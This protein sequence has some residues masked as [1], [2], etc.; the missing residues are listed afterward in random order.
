M[1]TIAENTTEVPVQ[2]LLA[3]ELMVIDGVCGGVT[4]IVI[5]LL[6]ASGHGP[7]DV[8]EQVIISPLFK[9][10]L[11][12]V[13][14]F[15]PA[16]TPFIAHCNTGE[17]PALTSVAVKFAALPLQ[18][19]VVFEVMLMP[20]LG[21]T[22]IVTLSFE[23]QPLLLLKAVFT[24]YFVII[25]LAVLLICVKTGLEILPALKLAAGVQA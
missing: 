17:A 19:E 21:N 7:G 12:N 2:I 23:M 9:D 3:V 24:K 1:L 25:G 22:V 20:G 6:V 18:T 11:L 16:A 10:E 8:T 13:V 14:A 15:V 5:A 4:V